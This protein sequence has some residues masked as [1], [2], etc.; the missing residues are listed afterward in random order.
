MRSLVI[1]SFVLQELSMKLLYL[2]IA[3]KC[4]K[5]TYS[6]Y[7]TSEVYDSPARFSRT[8]NRCILNEAGNEALKILFSIVVLESP[9]S[10]TVAFPFPTISL[11]RFPGY[12]KQNK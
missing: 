4:Y 8:P 7:I 2:G 11:N 6:I 5:E 10:L 3:K 9:S 1:E 12:L